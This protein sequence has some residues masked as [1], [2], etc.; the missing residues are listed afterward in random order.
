MRAQQQFRRLAVSKQHY[1]SLTALPL[2]LTATTLVRS[3]GQQSQWWLGDSAQLSTVLRNGPTNLVASNGRL[4]VG[5]AVTGP[6]LIQLFRGLQD[7]TAS[8]AISVGTVASH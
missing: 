2:L 1:K 3:K 4:S 6:A 7:N 8:K 5:A